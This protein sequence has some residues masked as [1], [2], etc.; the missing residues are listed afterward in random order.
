MGEGYRVITDNVITYGD[1]EAHPF[2]LNEQSEA[3]VNG[4]LDIDADLDINSV[5]FWVNQTFFNYIGGED[6][7]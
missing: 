7:K 5:E 3:A 4:F 6:F 2:S 1:Y